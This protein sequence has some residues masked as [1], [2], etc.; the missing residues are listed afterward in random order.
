MFVKAFAAYNLLTT[1]SAALLHRQSGATHEAYQFRLVANVV[2]ADLSPSVQ[3]NGVAFNP[4]GC[5][6]PLHVATKVGGIPWYFNGTANALVN[7]GHWGGYETYAGVIVTPGGTATMP[8]N[9][10]VEVGCNQT[11]PELRFSNDAVPHLTYGDGA[12]MACPGEVLGDDYS[13]RLTYKKPGQLTLEGCA[14]IEL[15]PV[16]ADDLEPEPFEGAQM[17]TCLSDWTWG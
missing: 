2:G 3:G 13:I 9:N 7:L 1:V 10:R 8:S 4:Y 16:C 12:W 17:V 14:D 6:G 5:R 15:W 11:T